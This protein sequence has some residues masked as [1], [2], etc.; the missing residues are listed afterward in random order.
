MQEAKGYR[1]KQVRLDKETQH[2]QQ[3]SPAFK[4]PKVQYQTEAI[5]IKSQF[6]PPRPKDGGILNDDMKKVLHDQE[7]KDYGISVGGRKVRVHKFVLVVH[8]YYNNVSDSE[9]GL[10]PQ[11]VRRRDEG[12]RQAGNHDPRRVGRKG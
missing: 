11:D 9:I 4:K 7:T 2:L 12:E 3:R 8:A 5:V 1:E 6:F 10:F